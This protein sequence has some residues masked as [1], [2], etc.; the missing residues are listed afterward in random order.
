MWLELNQGQNMKPSRFLPLHRHRSSV[1]VVT[2]CKLYNPLRRIYIQFSLDT[3]ICFSVVAYRS[4]RI[5]CH[6]MYR[7]VTFIPSFIWSVLVEK[8]TGGWEREHVMCM[9]KWKIDNNVHL[10]TPRKINREMLTQF[11]QAVIPFSTCYEFL[12]IKLDPTPKSD[13]SKLYSVKPL[14]TKSHFCTIRSQKQ[15][16]SPVAEKLQMLE[17]KINCLQTLTVRI[18]T[19]LKVYV[20]SIVSPDCPGFDSKGFGKQTFLN[21]FI[22]SLIV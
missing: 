1:T 16:Q 11:I 14:Y 19:Y 2:Y 17:N 21:S 4:W 7:L 22:E 5:E 12:F 9:A 6:F 20:Y 3:W 18:G 8:V 10:K 13:W 15:W